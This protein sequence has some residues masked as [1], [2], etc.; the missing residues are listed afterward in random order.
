MAAQSADVMLEERRELMVSPTGGNPTRRIAHF[1]KPSTTS[2][3][4]LPSLPIPFRIPDTEPQK[5]PM[6][7]YF[8]GWKSQ[9]SKWKMWVE[10]LHS[11]HHSTW[12]KAG[13]YDGIMASVYEI[14]RDDELVYAIAAKWCLETNTFVFP[15]G[16]ATVT[17]EDV[18]ILGGF[19]V[20]G[21]SVSAPL[22]DKK[23]VETE[24]RLIAERLQ[25]VRTKAQKACQNGWMNRLMGSGS[26]IEHEAFLSMW[27]SRFVL[28]TKSNCTIEKPVFSIA[29]RLAKGIPVALGPAVLASI[30]R[31]L[32]LLKQT[33]MALT[34]I[35]NY[36]KKDSVFALSLL[37]PLRLVQAW[38]WERFPALRPQPKPMELGE[39]RL[40]RWHKVKGPIVENVGVALD[41]ERE[42][43]E[44]RPYA[45]AVGN[46]DFPKFYGEREEWVLMGSGLD[47]E[48][49][50]FAQFLR[51]CK[52]VG[53]DDSMECYFPHRVGMQ[54]GMD[55][56]IPGHVHPRNETPEVAWNNYSKPINDVKLYIP[57]RFFE[58]D[59]TTR[60]LE[61]WNPSAKK[62][63]ND[64]LVPPGF[65]AKHDL[66]DAGEG[67]D[68]LVPPGFPAKHNRTD[69][70]EGND[71]LHHDHSTFHAKHSRMDAG[72]SS[73]EDQMT[74]RDMFKSIRN[75]KCVG[76]NS[77]TA[78]TSTSKTRVVRNDLLINSVDNIF[79]GVT[80]SEKGIENAND[81]SNRK[82]ATT[83]GGL[84][85]PKEDSS[86]SNSESVTM[87][88]GA[89]EV[90]EKE[91]ESNVGSPAMMGKS[92]KA[93][94]DAIRSSAKKAPT[95]SRLEKAMDD[96]SKIKEMRVMNAIGTIEI[97]GLDLEARISNL[98]RVVAGLKA[99][100]FRV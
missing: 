46:W 94:E 80:S 57:S 35:V 58:A 100:R 75:L 19:P 22:K 72:D 92:E 78:S 82:T 6:K 85:R 10:A 16:E 5:W 69:A 30:Y 74:I 32:G 37:A 81:E 47:K 48:L 4:G 79:Q 77:E 12:K 27:L 76:K 99:E 95:M 21:K 60:Y 90:N 55:Q 38:V 61:W 14:R 42:S 62:E 73:D 39:P 13:I 20:L 49:Q 59:V 83:A 15:W 98:E 97:P 65:P 40:S 25:V 93:M 64:A 23:M 3:N 86:R 2:I 84:E 88:G 53:I 43:F 87:V 8:H 41:L 26:P 11:A 31:D 89:E 45:R 7:V 52:L 17:L 33:L 96:T 9:K 56:D 68:A 54:F 34:K 24:E 29:I 63:G 66:T 91:N 1:L 67:N 28:S 50:A 44:W 70:G 71:A 36:K 51:V 18:M